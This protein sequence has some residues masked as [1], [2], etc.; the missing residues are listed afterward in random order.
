[1]PRRPVPSRTP[2][3]PPGIRWF[4]RQEI[5]YRISP[6]LRRRLVERC[7]R[8]QIGAV[9]HRIR[10]ASFVDPKHRIL[11]VETPK[12]ASTSILMAFNRMHGRTAI[13]PF[14]GRMRETKPEMFVHSRKNAVLLPLTAMEPDL[15]AE[16]FSSADWL[17]FAFVRNPYARLFSLWLNKIFICE[18][19]AEQIFALL[20]RSVPDRLSCIAD[21][22]AFDEF[23]MKIVRRVDPTSPDQHF[24]L[25]ERLLWPDFF[26]YGLIG[27]IENFAE[28]FARVRAHAKKHGG[29]LPEPERH[30]PTLEDWRGFYDRSLAAT[31]AEVYAPDFARFG[32]E[33]ALDG[34]SL[35]AARR[36][37]GPDALAARIDLY[38][39]IFKR[40]RLFAQLYELEI[41]KPAQ[42]LRLRAD[43]PGTGGAGG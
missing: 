37:G 22:V 26:E 18:P 15:Q 8:E 11:Y 19:G 30:N 24:Q 23:V 34:R 25:Q 42:R 28:D 17:R 29:E 4:Q 20:G 38:N 2:A 10:Y 35:A 9:L 32:Y 31:V 14:T 16:V 13:R 5:P 36:K 21:S 7:P 41:G 12:V 6:P 43:I 39:E 40:N 27:K 1:M 33:A 3:R